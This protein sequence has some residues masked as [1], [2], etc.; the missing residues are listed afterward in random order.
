MPQAG[1]WKGWRYHLVNLLR[2]AHQARK[3]RFPKR[4]AFLKDYPR[5]SG[6]LAK[7]YQIT[8]YAHIGASLLDPR[9]TVRYIG[10]YTKRAVLAEYR[11]THY[12][13]KTVRF[14]FRDYA[15]GRKTSFKTFPVHAFI[16]ALIRHIPDKGFPTVR[17]AGLFAPR[18]K[19]SYLAQARRAIEA[20]NR[21]EA[22]PR[23]EP[24]G[25]PAVTPWRQRQMAL[26]GRDP[27][28]CVD[29]GVS[30]IE[31]GAIFGSHRAVA[32]WF[33]RAERPPCPWSPAPSQS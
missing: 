8:W 7:L 29:C 3:L 5:F 20:A 6:L 17:H 1:L 10:R 23:R 9:F 27:L 16:A 26:L 18:W 15:E 12:D 13:G 32:H 22:H 24:P 4:F 19:A 25:L 14:A 31:V 28:R 21:N 33:H 11:I 2:K 30:L